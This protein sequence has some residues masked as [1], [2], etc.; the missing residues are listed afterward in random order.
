L[1]LLHQIAYGKYSS[2]EFGFEREVVEKL[3]IDSIPVPPFEN[4]VPTDLEEIDGLFETLVP[5]CINK[6]SLR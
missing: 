1:T 3:V 6:R 5:T 4:L 2:G